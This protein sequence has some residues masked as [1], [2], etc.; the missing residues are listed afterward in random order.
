MTRDELIRRL[1]RLARDRGVTFYV[2]TEQ[3]KGSH[4]VVRFGDQK[5]PIPQARGRDLRTGTL[6][7]I[8]RG[9]GLTSRDLE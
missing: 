4:W 6:R 9:L 7:A 8:L 2:D 3:G 5:Q 1:R